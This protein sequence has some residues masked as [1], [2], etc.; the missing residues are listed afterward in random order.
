VAEF[1]AV[2]THEANQ[3]RPSHPDEAAEYLGALIEAGAKILPP[4]PGMLERL[5]RLAAEND[6]L[7]ARIFDLQI[8]LTAYEAGAA[9]IWPHDKRFVSHP[10]L[11]VR[12]PLP[13]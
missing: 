3:R 12:D 11:P 10:E 4:R 7:G 2:V 13:G 5:L 9:E 1:W 8:A 6:I